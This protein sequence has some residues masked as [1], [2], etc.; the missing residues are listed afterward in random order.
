MK[1]TCCQ[2]LRHPTR[3]P[4]GRHTDLQRAAAANVRWPVGSTVRVGFLNGD[5]G[6]NHILRLWVMAAAA[7]WRQFANL[8]WDFQDGAAA[9]DVTV[10]FLPTADA[11]YGTYSSALGTEAREFVSAG[12]PSVHLVFDPADPANDATELARVCLH[13]WGHVLGL[14][15]EHER[16]DRP[17]SFDLAA[18]VAYYRELT[19]GTWTEAEIQQQ[20]I[21]PY[22]GPLA[23]ETAF[24]TKSIMMYPF[25]AGLATYA[26]G[27]P[28]QTGWNEHLT[29]HDKQL[30]AQLYPR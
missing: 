8:S 1:S 15:H 16:P 4:F 25:P 19:G 9:A 13:E 2:P 3:L 18:T 23:G 11:G 26:D 17:I 6:A 7:T 12:L 29:A 20:V 28:F 27:S 21:N 14:I 24:D 30:A 10:N 22:T 5:S